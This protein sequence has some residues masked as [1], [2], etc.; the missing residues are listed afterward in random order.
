MYVSFA[1]AH[2]CACVSPR[3]SPETT[4]HAGGAQPQAASN[5]FDSFDAFASNGRARRW[6]DAGATE[7]CS[8]LL[9]TTPGAACAMPH[10]ALQ[11]SLHVRWV[12]RQLTLAHSSACGHARGFGRTFPN[13]NRPGLALQVDDDATP[14]EIKLAYRSLTKVCHPE[15]YRRG[16]PQR[17][18]SAERGMWLFV[19]AGTTCLQERGCCTQCLPSCRCK[20]PT[21]APRV[22]RICKR[23]AVRSKMSLPRLSSPRAAHT[24]TDVQAVMAALC[25]TSLI[26]SM[27]MQ[28]IQTVGRFAGLLG[29]E[30]QECARHLQSAATDRAARRV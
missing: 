20:C 26:E 21:I 15:L 29:P 23:L 13:I 6:R 18:H 1:S 3:K 27:T 17:L 9:R 8:G 25:C 30:Q 28:P 10:V 19:S 24:A 7:R 2:M 11:V 22:P 4:T 16:R 5:S 12:C 14:A